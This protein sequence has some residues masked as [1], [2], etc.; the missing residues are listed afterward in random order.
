MKTV[1]VTGA[2]GYIGSILTPKL[3]KKGYQVIAV[4]RFFFGRDKLPEHDNLTL[5]QEDV[6]RLTAENLPKNVDAIIDLVAISNDPSG[7]LFQDATY[8]INRDAR[9]NLATIAKAAGVK[10]YI[11]PSSCSI[12]GF[13]ENIVDETASTN[14]LTTYAKANLEAENGIL[15]LA[16]DTFCAT[17]LRQATVYG[18]SPRMRFDLAINGMTYGAWKDHQ[19][20]LMRDGTQYRPMV[21]VQDTTDVMCKMLE[22]P[23]EKINGQIFNV[24]S[25]AQ[26]YQLGALAKEIAQ[27][28]KEKVN[29]EVAIEWYGDADIRSYQVDFS[30]LKNTLDWSPSYDAKKGALE[31]VDQLEAGQLEKT[32]QTITLRWYQLLQ[33]WQTRLQDVTMHN[34]L[35]NIG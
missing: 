16:D 21:H 22:T 31:I 11:L 4:D 7:E 32:D 26:N 33:E 14:P 24:G 30:K 17:V 25:N 20:M 5:M 6:R 27:A 10:Q 18:A 19:L 35:L 15:P 23:A 13:Q 29:Q 3:L 2:G 34:G 1:L 9:V 12:Y 28:I 8:G